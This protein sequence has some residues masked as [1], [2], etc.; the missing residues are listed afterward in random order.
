MG[1]TINL[2]Q[3]VGLHDWV[4]TLM[5]EIQKQ[6][7]SIPC[8]GAFCQTNH[9]STRENP[10]L[11]RNVFLNMDETSWTD[12]HKLNPVRVESKVGL[13]YVSPKQ[14]R[15]PKKCRTA[16]LKMC[17]SK[18]HSKYTNKHTNRTCH[19]NSS[20]C[21]RIKIEQK[22]EK[23]KSHHEIQFP[24]NHPVRWHAPSP[25]FSTG[26]FLPIS[27]D[28]PFHSND[29]NPSHS[30]GNCQ[31]W[32]LP[33]RCISPGARL[34]QRPTKRAVLRFFFK[35]VLRC[36]MYRKA[37]V[38]KKNRCWRVVYSIFPNQDIGK[39]KQYETWFVL[40][41]NSSGNFKNHSWSED[42]WYWKIRQLRWADAKINFHE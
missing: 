8:H 10:L 13:G 17:L 4:Y 12:E 39:N 37:D 36:K 1:F 6:T 9:A 26:R 30:S 15:R 3:L 33:L 18:E 11:G 41:N 5:R 19:T 28:G 27:N 7:C 14:R 40:F 32:Q 42:A 21:S 31:G 16:C 35:G 29:S 24:S 2:D 22:N 34:K 23:K 38:G 20:S 25:C